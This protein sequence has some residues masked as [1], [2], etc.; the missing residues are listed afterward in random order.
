MAK[1]DIPNINSQFASQQ[2]LN[3]RFDLIEDA[4]NNKVL[5]R[6]HE[7]G[8]PNQMEVELDMNLND[9]IN[10]PYPST[11]TSPIRI[12]DLDGLIG[13]TPGTPDIRQTQVFTLSDGQTQVVFTVPIT[14]GDLYI[15]GSQV[16]SGR[17]G[18]NSEYTING[19]TV[20]LVE[21]YPAGTLLTF[22]T[23]GII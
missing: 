19:Q 20:T 23:T 6:D 16:D 9:I 21:S 12:Q 11:P 14:A 17:L 13:T 10:L 4:L 2:G 5:F 3:N 8:E 22:I 15:N 18:L 1:I 7:V